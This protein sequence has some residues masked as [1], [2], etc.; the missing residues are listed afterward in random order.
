MCRKLLTGFLAAVLAFSIC[1]TGALAVTP[2]YSGQLGHCN[3]YGKSVCA[4]KNGDG[5]CDNHGDS[6]RRYGQHSVR[7]NHMCRR[8]GDSLCHFTVGGNWVSCADAD[9]NGLCDTCGRT[10]PVAVGNSG[11]TSGNAGTSGNTWNGG[12]G[13]GS[14]G[15]GNGS[16][17]G[18]S[19]GSSGGSYGNY[20]SGYYGGG[21]CGSSGHHSSGHHG[22]HG[23]H[24]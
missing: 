13:G 16:Y 3:V 18:G 9:C 5:I 6:C 21:Y 2:Y 4:D 14:T 24:C 19:T 8:P 17:G 23:G 15:N 10:M 20:G 22:G 11:N 12:N 1:S 7:R